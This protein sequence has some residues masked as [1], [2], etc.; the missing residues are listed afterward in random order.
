MTNLTPEQYARCPN[1]MNGN[2]KW[3]ENIGKNAG[4]PKGCVYCS[5]LAVDLLKPELLRGR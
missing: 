2:H 5:R 1:S 4:K 3:R